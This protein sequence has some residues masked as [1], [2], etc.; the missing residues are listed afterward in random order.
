MG[1]VR[2]SSPTIY[3]APTPMTA[4]SRNRKS[5]V[6]SSVM[7]SPVM[8]A[9]TTE[10]KNAAMQMTM[11]ASAYDASSPIAAN[12]RLMSAPSPAPTESMG[13]NAP[14][15]TPAPILTAVTSALT[16]T[17]RRIVAQSGAP[18]TDCTPSEPLPRSAMNPCPPPTA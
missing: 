9:L 5:Q 11:S 6:S 3:P 12:R 7:T 17:T 10:V 18:N 15:G 1:F 8:G 14:Q 13:T 2:K 16:A 4:G